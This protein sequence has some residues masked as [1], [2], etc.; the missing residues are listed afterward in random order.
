MSTGMF[1]QEFIIR[2]PDLMN[3]SA[4]T[5][6]SYNGMEAIVSYL[7]QLVKNDQASPP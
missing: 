7:L 4:V 2:F 5:V 1:P 3:I 6:D